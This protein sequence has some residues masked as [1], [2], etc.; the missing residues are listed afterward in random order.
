MAKAT[1]MEYLGRLKFQAAE[2]D[3][4]SIPDNDRAARDAAS[5]MVYIRVSALSSARAT[6]NW[7]RRCA[8]MMM[9]RTG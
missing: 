4:T 2:Y 6:R 8:P 1:A 5:M 9:P 7:R 3:L